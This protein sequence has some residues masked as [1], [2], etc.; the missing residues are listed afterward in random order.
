MIKTDARHPIALKPLPH[1]DRPRTD[2][3]ESPYV[4]NVVVVYEDA[5]SREWATEVYERIET[6]AGY[7]GAHTTWWRISDLCEPG[8]LAGAVSTALRADVILVAA[9]ATEGLPLPFYVWVKQWLPNRRPPVGALVALLPAIKGQRSR[10]GRVGQYLQAVAQ[11]GRMDFFC[12]HR[13]LTTAD[14]APARRT[15]ARASQSFQTAHR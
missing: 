11:Q 10:P 2:S 3:A 8:V 5:V 15:P 4:L 6:I 7:E 14:P 13:L 9:C 1:L 12:E